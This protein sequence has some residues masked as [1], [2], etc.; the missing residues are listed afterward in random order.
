[1]DTAFLTP[2]RRIQAHLLVARKT[3]KLKTQ[4]FTHPLGDGGSWEL[5]LN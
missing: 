4:A 2:G 1:M 5:R 3:E